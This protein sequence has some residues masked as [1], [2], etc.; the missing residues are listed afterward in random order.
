MF[1]IVFLFG[2][3]IGSFLNAVIYRLEANDSVFH[4]RSYCPKCK[5]TLS[6]HDLIP[7]VSFL[8]LRG[9]CRYCKGK[10]SI[11]YPFVELA[12]AL[13]FVAIVNAEFL[14]VLILEILYVF[15]IASLLIVL[16]VYDLKHYMLP[17]KIL[18]PA[19]FLAVGHQIGVFCVEY[20]SLIQNGTFEIGV[21]SQLANPFLAA[22]GAVAFFFAI[23]AVSGG[24]AMGFGDVK[25]AGFMG[26]FL[27]W[28]NIMVALFAAFSVGA[29]VGLYLIFSKKKE[30]KSEVPF[31][32]FLIGGTACAFFFGNAVVDWYL[33]LVLV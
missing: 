10:I 19:I 27:G 32:P 31:G 5:H 30:M 7:V 22:L 16:F 9:T 17:D 2:L 18:I 12:T 15:V 29:I 28:P 11:Q 33:R 3:V 21:L 6:W 4:G 14:H 13:V 1:V 24:R 20:W 23:F 25:L 8:F 26:L